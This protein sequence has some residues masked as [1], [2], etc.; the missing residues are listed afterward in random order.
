VCTLAIYLPSFL[1]VLFAAPPLM[2]HRANP[3]VQG[4]TKAVYAVAIGAILGASLRLGWTRFETGS[5]LS[6]W[7]QVFSP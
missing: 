4:F 5:P 7:R 2:R 6:S 3:L 1:L